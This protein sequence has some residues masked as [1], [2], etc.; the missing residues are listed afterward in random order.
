MV[1]KLII[2]SGNLYKTAANETGQGPSF[3]QQFGILADAQITDKYPMLGNYQIASQLLDKSDD[4]T[5]ATCIVIYKLGNEYIQVPAIYKN[6]RISTGEVMFVPSTSTFLPLSDAWMS[7]IKNKDLGDMGQNV[8]PD[9][10]NIFGSTPASARAS[11]ITDPIMKTAS[12][13]QTTLKLG[14]K[15]TAKWL[16][17]LNNVDCLNEAFK[18]YS[19]QDIEN[20]A[21]QA[22]AKYEEVTEDIEVISV[23]DKQASLLSD[24]LKAKLYRDGFLVKKANKIDWGPADSQIKAT[25]YVNMS[26]SF[27][28]PSS[29]CKCKILFND[30]SLKQY[31]YIP[32]NNTNYSSFISCGHYADPHNVSGSKWTN[33][34]FDSL[35]KERSGSFLVEGNLYTPVGSTL[36]ALSSTIEDVD[37]K[38]IGKSLQSMEEIPT[39]AII[40]CPNKK[41]IKF[42]FQRFIKDKND[43]NKFY[44]S[45]SIIQI[46]EDDNLKKPIILDKLVE[47]PKGCRILFNSI[48]ND[49]NGNKKEQT[50]DIYPSI[51]PVSFVNI[52]KVLQKFSKEHTNKLKITSDGQEISITGSK[53]KNSDRLNKKEAVLHLVKDYGLSPEEA[54]DM[55]KDAGAASIENP[56]T[57]KYMLY[58]E[59]DDSSMWEPADIGMTESTNSAPTIENTDLTGYAGNE[60]QQLQIIRNAAD[61]GIK[62]IF[63]AQVLKLLL[64][65]A[66]PYEEVTEALPDFMVTLDKLC[67][68][69]FVYRTHMQDMQQRYGAV[70]MKAL[71]S[72]L[73]NT[74]KDLSELTIFLKLR[75][76]KEGQSPDTGQLQTGTMMQ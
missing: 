71:Q 70:K 31:I 44:N 28:E 65:N 3:E 37:I 21:K 54:K 39:D 14:K 60:Q 33:N 74:I 32:D 43:P 26:S 53:S 34:A 56:K 7:W 4:N 38:D 49:N 11:Q 68:L 50:K 45:S 12:L 18:F 67:R 13:F 40:L 51:A 9:A 61:S 10:Q 47:L 1:N 6:G 5:S 66:D 8:T 73:Q 62:E 23:L 58:K 46:S 30:G 20:F 24:Q 75:G 25:K 2:E 57:F 69:L 42:D 35:R 22:A 36:A 63:D 41:I 17:K 55:I 15:A 29:V 19:P 27:R 72:S 59:A 52:H 48:F 16:D 76:L 64:Q